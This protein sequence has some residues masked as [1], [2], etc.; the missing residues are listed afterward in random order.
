MILLFNNFLITKIN[1]LENSG[2]GK[3]VIRR[4]KVLL[5]TLDYGK[6]SACLLCRKTSN[7]VAK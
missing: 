3:V 2:L 7:V 4:A 1:T 5:D 6:F